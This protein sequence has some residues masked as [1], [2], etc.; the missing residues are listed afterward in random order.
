MIWLKMKKIQYDNNREAAKITT[1]SSGKINKYEFFTGE[2]IWTLDQSRIIEQA[3]FTHCY[4]SWQ[5]NGDKKIY[6][7]TKI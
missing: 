2:E 3:K 5:N 6:D 4:L 1:L 7:I